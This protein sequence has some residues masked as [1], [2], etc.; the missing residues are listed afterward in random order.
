MYGD[1]NTQD[2]AIG[3]RILSEHSMFSAIKFENG[4]YCRACCG[5]LGKT[6]TTLSCCGQSSVATLARSSAWRITI[7]CCAERISNGFTT[8]AK[9]CRPCHERHDTPADAEN[10]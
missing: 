3:Q 8:I 5:L 10:A 2:I 4:D 7:R 6:T 1:F 9:R